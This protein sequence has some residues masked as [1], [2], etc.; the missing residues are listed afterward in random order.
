[1]QGY[2]AVLTTGTDEHGQKVERAAQRWANRRRSS[3]PSSPHEFR[4]QWE[5]LGL[6]VDRF[7]RTTDPQASQDS[8]R[9]VPALPGER[10]RL[11][12]RYTGQYCVFDELYVNDAKPGDPCPDCG[13]PTETV[14]EENYFFKLSAFQRQAARALRERIPISSSPRRAATK[15]IAFVQAGP[16]RSLHQPH[17]ASNGASRCRSKASTSSTSGSTR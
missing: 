6:R 8:R 11:Q 17:H 16:E 10:L 1:M 2:D 3:P 4:T 13:R 14:T 5:K 9:V 15:C 7:I 12:G